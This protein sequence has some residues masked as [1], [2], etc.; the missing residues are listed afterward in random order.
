MNTATQ[1]MLL[2]GAE[3]GFEAGT[4]VLLPAWPCHVDVSFKLWGAFNT[5]VEVAFANGALVSLNVVPA[6]RAA[7][8]KFA[9]CVPA[10][11]ADA[12]IAEHLQRASAA[13]V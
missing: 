6:A 10:D 3:D 8:V 9:A 1:L 11:V 2:Q 5:S 13:V 7:A 12:A 4:I